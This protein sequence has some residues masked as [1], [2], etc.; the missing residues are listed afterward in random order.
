MKKNKI[1]LI[2]LLAMS[3]FSCDLI[4][5]GFL[6]G[7]CGHLE[8]IE[9]NVYL[10]MDSS[11]KREV[12]FID[13]QRNIPLKI[14]A[15]RNPAYED[16]KSF[17]I[18]SSKPISMF[19]DI[20]ENGILDT[21]EESSIVNLTSEPKEVEWVSYVYGGSKQNLAGGPCVWSEGS[22]A[23]WTI[24]A[25]EGFSGTTE[26]TVHS[27]SN[28]EH[29]SEVSETAKVHIF[30]PVSEIQIEQD[31]IEKDY[32]ATFKVV[33][34]LNYRIESIDN[35][36]ALGF[37]KYKYVGLDGKTTIKYDYRYG[38]SYAYSCKGSI[39]CTLTVNT[40]EHQLD[41]ANATKSGGAIVTSCSN[42]EAYK[43]YRLDTTNAKKPFDPSLDNESDR[44]GLG[45]AFSHDWDITGVKPGEYDVYVKGAP[46]DSQK[47]LKWIINVPDSDSV[48]YPYKLRKGTNET[49]PS[50]TLSFGETF[51][52]GTSFRWTTS[53]IFRVRINEGDKELTL[54]SGNQNGSLYDYVMHINSLLLVPS[55]E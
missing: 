26:I 10:G 43:T 1:I 23:R 20:N 36:T 54:T 22:D 41:E 53:K 52:E 49:F 5:G 19:R 32:E 42:C 4:K 13:G 55:I 24:F 15:N 8:G 37:N 44:L 40:H 34:S 12:A 17:T 11:F 3:L 48:L 18:S 46:A 16:M 51:G 29:S 39:N 50:T 9:T 38:P 31:P 14:E 6:Y 45:F 27:V 28:G 30:D 35:A 47:D 33:A 2:P 25:R 21:D 7:D